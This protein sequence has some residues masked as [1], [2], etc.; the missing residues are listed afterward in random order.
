MRRESRLLSEK[1][2][3]PDESDLV[4]KLK[5]TVATWPVV[6]RSLRSPPAPRS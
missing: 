2:L 5:H 6:G 4:E 1:R 3:S